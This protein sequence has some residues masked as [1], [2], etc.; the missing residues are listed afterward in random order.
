M[1]RMV[2]SLSCY[3][4]NILYKCYNGLLKYGKRCKQRD[5]G[6]YCM[7]C[8]YC[9]AEISA[10]DATRLLESYGKKKQLNE[11]NTTNKI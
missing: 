3:N 9:K 5:D 7:K 11:K 1:K 2:I 4:I 10:Y 6:S 8:K